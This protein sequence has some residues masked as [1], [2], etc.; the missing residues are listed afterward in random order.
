MAPV[1]RLARDDPRHR[2]REGLEHHHVARDQLSRFMSGVGSTNA[3]R[4]KGRHP[5]NN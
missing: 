1:F 3:Y 5:R 4:L 2:T